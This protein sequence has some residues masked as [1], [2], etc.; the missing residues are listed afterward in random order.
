MTQ[1][2][3]LFDFDGTI[4]KSDTLLSFIRYYSNNYNLTA[5]LLRLSPDILLWKLTVRTTQHTKEKVFKFFFGNA[6]IEE[7][8]KECALFAE[9]IIPTLVNKKAMQLLVGYKK[10]H[11]RIV[12]VSASPENWV[13]PWCDSQSIDCIATRLEVVA[14]R[15]TGNINGLNS[16][17]PEKERRIREIIDLRKYDH[18]V[19]YGNG[20]GDFEM[21]QLASESHFRKI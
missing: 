9:H 18:I 19:A 7:F 1:K 2:L 16:S 14:N 5:G 20:R 21:F 17:G 15:I 8:N 13:K 3:V 10:E 12:V 6:E 11:A 4:T